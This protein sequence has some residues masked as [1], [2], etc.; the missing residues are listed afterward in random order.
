ML[1]ARISTSDLTQSTPDDVV[2]INDPVAVLAVLRVGHDRPVGGPRYLIAA[3][4]RVCRCG[5][6]PRAAGLQVGYPERE[7]LVY[8]RDPGGVGRPVKFTVESGAKLDLA[9]PFHFARAVSAPQLQLV[10][11]VVIGLVAE[12][13][14]IRRERRIAI[15][16]VRRVC[17]VY[18]LPAQPV[19][20]DDIAARLENDLIAEPR[21]RCRLDVG[22]DGYGSGRELG[23][24]GA[25]LDVDAIHRSGRWIVASDPA[26]L[27]KDEHAAPGGGMC[28]SVLQVSG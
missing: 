17:D 23:G 27:D 7:A 26:V 5:D 9:R 4:I 11:A 1:G 8:E 16:D 18:S 15:G 22:G 14:A 13:L 6:P 24:V 28:N 19:V 2:E 20:A 3:L 12:P 25:D 10:F 21:D